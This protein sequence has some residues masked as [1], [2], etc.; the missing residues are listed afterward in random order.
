MFSISQSITTSGLTYSMLKITL[1]QNEQFGI[2]TCKALNY[3]GSAEAYVHLIQ[4]YSV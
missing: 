1:L 4:S 3:I 2:Y